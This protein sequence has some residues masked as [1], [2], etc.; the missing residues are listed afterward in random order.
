MWSG[1]PGMRVVL[2]KPTENGEGEVTPLQFR[3]V[4]LE[5]N[6]TTDEYE[7]VIYVAHVDKTK[8]NE[9]LG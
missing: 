4:A 3:Q 7:Q 6:I 2:Y 8:Q 1:M 9:I 5:I